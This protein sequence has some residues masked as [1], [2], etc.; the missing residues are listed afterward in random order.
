VEVINDYTF[1]QVIENYAKD[2]SFKNQKFVVYATEN[3]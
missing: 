1:V 2:S 3:E